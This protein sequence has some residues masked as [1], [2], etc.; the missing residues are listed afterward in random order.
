MSG[1]LPATS[2]RAGGESVSGGLTTVLFAVVVVAA[3]YFGRDVLVPVALA[4][5]L[6]FV[7]ARGDAPRTTIAEVMGEHSVWRGGQRRARDVL[8]LGAGAAAAP[9]G[10]AGDHRNV[11]ATCCTAVVYRS[12]KIK[13]EM[14]NGKYA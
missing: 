7:L 8:L 1:I 10:S 3:L 6:S 12:A 13:R 14:Q 4:M 5:L 11:T 9:R 2:W